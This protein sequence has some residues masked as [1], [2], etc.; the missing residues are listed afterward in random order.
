MST[1]ESPADEGGNL[2]PLEL[3]NLE[4]SASSNDDPNQTNANLPVLW[5]VL[6]ELGIEALCA[7]ESKSSSV[8]VFE[9]HL[10]GKVL[11]EQLAALAN[12]SA[13]VMRSKDVRILIPGTSDDT[14]N[15]IVPICGGTPICL[16]DI[17]AADAWR[18]STAILPIAIG[19]DGKGRP[20]IGDVTELSHLLIGGP[21]QESQIILDANGAEKLEG[22]ADL[23]YRPGYDEH[24]RT[25]AQGVAID[26]A[27]IKR[28]VEFIANQ[29]SQK[30]HTRKTQA[31]LTDD[32]RQHAGLPLPGD[33]TGIDHSPNTG[34][35]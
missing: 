5:G 14:I 13:V 7:N 19:Q 20:I 4:P 30:T 16:R 35:S 8:V 18:N 26:D 23:I 31:L 24:E 25:R 32:H 28:I 34:A 15:L 2:L 21:P 3:L 9:L 33:Q 6:H 11:A 22:T 17:L 10:T 12:R 29:T 1:A 27:E